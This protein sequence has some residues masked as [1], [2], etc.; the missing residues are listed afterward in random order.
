MDIYVEMRKL[1]DENDRLRAQVAELKLRLGAKKSGSDKCI[2][3]DADSQ[4]CGA[5]IECRC[6]GC[7]FYKT[8]EKYFEDLEKSEK[9]L[10]AKGLEAITTKTD[11]LKKRTVTKI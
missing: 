6:D 4:T 7:K 1:R 10:K 5:L 11:G 9:L 3:F 2:F 8:Q